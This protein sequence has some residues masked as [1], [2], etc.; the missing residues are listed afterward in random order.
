MGIFCLLFNADLLKLNITEPILIR[1]EVNQMAKPKQNKNKAPKKPEKSNENNTNAFADLKKQIESASDERVTS[2]M[3]RLLLQGGT[4]AELLE[5]I[6]KENERLGSK[7][8]K[9]PGRIKSH[10]KSRE[11]MGWVFT[12]K[13]DG[14]KLTGFGKRQ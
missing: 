6:G 10:I 11:R 9:T 1:K 12:Y 8:F 14:V 13:D 7:D 5:Q 4:F 3:D 2:C